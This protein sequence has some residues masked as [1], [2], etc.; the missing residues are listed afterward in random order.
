MNRRA[1]NP[2]ELAD[3]QRDLV[4]KLPE[5]EREAVTNAFYYFEVVGSSSRSFFTHLLVLLGAVKYWSEDFPKAIDSQSTR[6]AEKIRESS[7]EL[8]ESLETYTS[9]LEE[10]SRQNTQLQ[11]GLSKEQRQLNQTLNSVWTRIASQLSNRRFIQDLGEDLG[12]VLISS[13]DRVRPQIEQSYQQLEAAV[14]QTTLHVQSVLRQNSQELERTMRDGAQNLHDRWE[15]LSVVLESDLRSAEEAKL[16][17]ARTHRELRKYALQI[18]QFN[19]RAYMLAMPVLLALGLVL[20][21]LLA[22]LLFRPGDGREASGNGT[23]PGSARPVE[24]WVIEA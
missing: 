17:L 9:T 18:E 15:N 1:D 14:N 10:L 12:R 6:A 13:Q 21:F 19:R 23:A 20:G 24:A 5:D 2:W 8:L 11:Q 22:F 7:R 3:W 16:E 4:S